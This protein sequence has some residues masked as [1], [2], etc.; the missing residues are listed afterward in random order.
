MATARPATRRSAA[1]PASPPA[2]PDTPAATASL[3]LRDACC[4][5]CRRAMTTNPIPSAAD[6]S[7]SVWTLGDSTTYVPTFFLRIILTKRR[8]QLWH[9][10]SSNVQLLVISARAIVGPRHVQ[11]RFSGKSWHPGDVHLTFP[12]GPLGHVRGCT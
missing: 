8:P 5:T 6:H 11:C 7:Y 12:F 3:K 9:D 1:Q 2:A 10:L 4:C